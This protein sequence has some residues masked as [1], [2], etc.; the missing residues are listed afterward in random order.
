MLCL[1]CPPLVWS[2]TNSN[3]AGYNSGIF[4]DPASP[5]MGAWMKL[6]PDKI[7]QQGL[8]VA[9]MQQD[10]SHRVPGFLAQGPKPIASLDDFRAAIAQ[11]P[12]RPVALTHRYPLSQQV[13]KVDTHAQPS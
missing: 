11:P 8:G 4:Y 6:L 13:P 7:I 10:T 1:Q 3:M 9:K 2:H 12:Q 5:S